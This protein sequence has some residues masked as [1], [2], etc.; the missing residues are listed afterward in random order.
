MFESFLLAGC[1]LSMIG[2]I[3]DNWG[4]NIQK[5][6][7]H[8]NGDSPTFVY[9]MNPRWAF[10]FVIYV[11][12]QIMNLVALG[13]IDQPTQS[14]LSSFALFSNI[15]F[16]RYYF[17]E[18]MDRRDVFGLFLIS[19]GASLFVFHFIHHKQDMTVAMLEERFFKPGFLLLMFIMGVVV[20]FCILYIRDQN[21]NSSFLSRLH[22]A[23]MF[24]RD[25]TALAYAV[26][27][28][29]NGGCTVTFS[30]ISTVLIQF[31]ASE[32]FNLMESQFMIL[33]LIIWIFMLF[34]SVHT[35]N[36]GLQNSPALVMIPIFY[37]LSNMVSILVGTIY[38]EEYDT[39]DSPW[40]T[41]VCFFGMV[42]TLSGIYIL[43]Q[44]VAALKEKDMVRKAEQ[45]GD[46]G[47]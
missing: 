20:G 26:L 16:A 14:I 25:Q 23:R 22:A 5:Y 33:I 24:Q 10:G 38:F 8:V 9:Y 34:S 17:N 4:M 2:S 13:L 36:L 35:L 46:M 3:I 47:P 39:F 41:F 21:R 11:G 42:M 44:R 6:A 43:S 28:A 1:A 19:C 40:L 15:L 27:A 31:I 45:R 32:D 30:K 37:V 12:G 29:V 18:V 7:H